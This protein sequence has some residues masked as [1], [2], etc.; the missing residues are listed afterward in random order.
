MSEREQGP[1]IQKIAGFVKLKR[2][3]ILHLC[4]ETKPTDNCRIRL[5]GRKVSII[6][7]EEAVK[8]RIHSGVPI[9]DV[10]GD[11]APAMAD[12]VAEMIRTLTDAGHFEIVL[13]I[14]RATIGGI[15]AMGSLTRMA[16]GLRSHCG[17][18]DVVGTADQINELVRAQTKRLFRL[19]VSEE[20][21]I[22]RIKRTP[23]LSTGERCTARPIA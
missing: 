3:G 21:A 4:S 6:M 18:M 15:T 22:G 20:M 19:A 11:W 10:L 12:S 9:V 16:Q 1:S 13:N 8:L 23:V 5:L 17:H 14:Q 2:D 7:D